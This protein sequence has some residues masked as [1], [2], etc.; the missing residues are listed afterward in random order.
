M[1]MPDRHHV[2]RFLLIAAIGAA[3]LFLLR[4]VLWLIF[5]ALLLSFLV[6]PL[7][8]LIQRKGA[9]RGAAALTAFLFLAL[10][11]V[12]VL[13]VVIP[14]LLTE[15]RQVARA[16]PRVVSDI[17]D[18]YA[19]FDRR[20]SRFHLPFDIRPALNAGLRRAQARIETAITGFAVGVPGILTRLVGLILAPV[21]AFYVS[22]DSPALAR[23]ALSNLGLDQRREITR[24]A[25]DINRALFGYLRGHLIVGAVVGTSTALGLYLL[26]VDFALLLGLLSGVFNIIPYFGPIFGGVP[27]V[28]L[29]LRR[30]SWTAVYVILLFF[31]INQLESTFISPRI[32]GEN[33]GLHPFVVIT[34]VLV[35]GHFL[36]IWGLLL[37]VPV[38]AMIKIVLPYLWRR[39]SPG[40]GATGPDDQT[41]AV[42]VRDGERIWLV[43]TV[44]GWSLPATQVRDDETREQACLRAA[45]ESLGFPVAIVKKLEGSVGAGKWQS[46]V[47]RPAGKTCEPRPGARPFAPVEAVLFLYGE[48]HQPG[49]SDPAFSGAVGDDGRGVPENPR[50]PS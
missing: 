9:S 33:V 3:L 36:G 44:A 13:A 45:R 19:L 20:F 15:L 42:A 22:R 1:L 47:A 11:L 40:G 27:A 31:G 49:K 7:V 29:A 35:G 43:E 37:A 41:V 28:L 24:M 21:L 39:T 23:K 30:S 32:V 8:E 16:L 34:A 12:L 17:Q 50:D 6:N 4:P 26:R 14:F 48:R 38:M 10:V 18:W 25:T 5:G 2:L 46:Y